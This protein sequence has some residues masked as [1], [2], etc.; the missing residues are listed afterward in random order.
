MPTPHAWPARL[1]LLPL[2]C[3]LGLGWRAGLAGRAAAGVGERDREAPRPAQA[4]YPVT[5]RLN[6]AYHDASPRQRLDLYLPQLPAGQSPPVLLFAPAG[7]WAAGDRTV[8]RPQAFALAELGL[9]VALV[10]HRVSDGSA[11]GVR[12]PEH[13]RDLARA[14]AFLRTWLLVGG[15]DT[16]GI[17]VGG[18]E[19]GAHLGALLAAD[20]RQLAEQ[21]LSPADLRG[22]IGL[23]GIYRIAPDDGTWADVFGLD[24]L[25]RGEASPHSH[26]RPSTP[27]MLL[28]NADG[29]SEARRADAA[30]LAEALIRAGS[31]GDARVIEGRSPASLL[32]FLG[33]PTDDATDLI[34]QF[35]RQRMA[36]RPRPTATPTAT[37]TPSPTPTPVDAFPP[38]LPPRGPGSAR[39]AIYEASLLEPRQVGDLAWWRILPAGAAAEDPLISAPLPV[40]VFLPSAEAAAEGPIAPYRRWLEHLALAGTVVIVPAY[41]PGPADGWRARLDQILPAALAE[42]R[43]DPD[44]DRRVDREVLYWAGHLEGGALAAALAADWFRLKLPLPRSLFLMQPRDSGS[45]V[46]GP[47]L[48]RLPADLQALTVAAA[49]DPAPDIALEELLWDRLAH[50]PSLWRERLVLRSDRYG[51]PAMNADHRA[52]YSDAPLGELDGLDGY[53]G[54]KWLD[55]LLSCGQLGADCAYAF[56]GGSEQLGMG[57]WADGHPARA[58]LRSAGPPRRYPW[59]GLLPWIGKRAE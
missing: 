47:A 25:T 1:A 54:W 22:V 45:W 2:I 5:E 29:D 21:G 56:G 40:L 28:V 9:G 18:H 16:G 43:A 15:L 58:A 42:L 4:R 8:Y 14:F 32:T 23:G 37:A 7:A 11:G 41:G 59:R 44:W 3:L 52:A 39:R 55:A 17:F 34:L 38:G 35:V 10:D 31:L 27:P 26:L 48:R 24:P 49:E 12:H 51:R 53:G 50:V 30:G 46:D 36:A 19:A 57:A 33:Q 13:V 6:L 20:P